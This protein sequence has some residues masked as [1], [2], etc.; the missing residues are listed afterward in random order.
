MESCL[1][2][3]KHGWTCEHLLQCSLG[4]KLNRAVVTQGIIMHRC[5]IFAKCRLQC[6]HDPVTVNEFHFDSAP[7]MQTSVLQQMHTQTG[8]SG[9]CPGVLINHISEALIGLLIDTNDK[10]LLH[11]VLHFLASSLFWNKYS[12]PIYWHFNTLPVSS[13]CSHFQPLSDG[14]QQY[15][16]AA[17]A[18]VR[19][20]FNYEG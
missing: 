6:L 16:A 11:Q 3:Q 5:G 15:E 8:A 20:Q 19:A 1:W 2:H 13:T 7:D 10:H 18:G 4:M 17:A 9:D 12:P 14:G